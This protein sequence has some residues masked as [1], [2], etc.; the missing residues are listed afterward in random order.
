[1]SLHSELRE[2]TAELNR[3]I[4]KYRG[5]LEEYRALD[6]MI[7]QNQGLEEMREEL[8][9]EYNRD[10]IL[11]R[12]QEI[13]RRMA[14]LADEHN[15]KTHAHPLLT[16]PNDVPGFM[17]ELDDRTYDVADKFS[18]RD[19]DEARRLRD[20]FEAKMKRQGKR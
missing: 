5:H 13:K 1:M 6:Y 11:G 12:I 3:L 17:K 19:K 2:C 18:V 9:R 16:D 4:D 8:Y 7:L 10:N 20:E 15:R 14:K